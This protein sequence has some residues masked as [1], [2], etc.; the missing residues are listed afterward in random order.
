MMIGLNKLS[1]NLNLSC[2]TLN[3]TSVCDIVQK[4]IPE[5]VHFKSIIK[6]FREI[7]GEAYPSI[8][9]DWVNGE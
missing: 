6:C 2:M 9:A 7:K 3:I 1:L 4:R 5:N 8:D